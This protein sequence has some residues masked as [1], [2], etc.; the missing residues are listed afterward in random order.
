M[1]EFEYGGEIAWRPS[2]A[3]MVESNLYQFYKR[4]GFNTLDEFMRVS[5]NDIAWFWDTVLHTLDIQFYEPYSQVVDLSDGI[6]FPK[7]C[8][9]GKMNIVHNCLDK[10]MGT[11]KENQLAIKWEGEEGTT[12][13]TDLWAALLA[14]QSDGERFARAGV[15]Q[16]GC[17]WRVYAHD[18]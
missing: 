5:T 18:A 14:S 1:S 3:Q 11:P 4:N 9:D 8:V 16:R 12:R 13:R 17:H 10:Y 15:G 6:Q 7:W 2:R